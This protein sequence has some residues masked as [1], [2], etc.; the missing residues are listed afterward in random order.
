MK[1]PGKGLGIFALKKFKLGELVVTEKPVFTHPIPIPENLDI[2]TDLD[3]ITLGAINS[4]SHGHLKLTTKNIVQINSLRIS[5]TSGGLFLLCSRF[6]H[7]CVDFNIRR[8]W[9]DKLGRWEGRATVDIQEGDEIFISYMSDEKPINYILREYLL[10][11][12]GFECKCDHCKDPVESDK[13]L[14]EMRDLHTSIETE[15][16]GKNQNSKSLNEQL[17]RFRRMGLEHGCINKLVLARIEENISNSYSSM[18]LPLE[19]RPWL[20]RAVQNTKVFVGEDHP[21]FRTVQKKLLNI[22][23]YMRM[24]DS[25]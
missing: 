22:I 3:E 1:S 11:S 21:R 17:I 14:K 7:D 23:A 8:N 18:Y 2:P 6:N 13:W 25:R 10:T 12:F 4:L 24:M 20:E 19:V 16:K 15:I 9:S 5:N